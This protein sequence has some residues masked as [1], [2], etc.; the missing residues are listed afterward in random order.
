M[1]VFARYFMGG[2]EGGYNSLHTFTLGLKRMD[3]PKP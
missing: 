3:F 2:A 1:A